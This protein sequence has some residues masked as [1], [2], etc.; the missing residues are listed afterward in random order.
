M[1]SHWFADDQTVT[2][3]LANLPWTEKT[4]RKGLLE[5]AFEISLF[6]L[7]SSHILFL[8]HLRTAAASLFCSFSE[9]KWTLGLGLRDK[10]TI[11]DLA[12]LA[13]NLFE[14]MQILVFQS[15]LYSMSI[16]NFFWFK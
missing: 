5:L 1:H 4:G 9:L 16:A 8:P 15:S 13:R 2:D 14:C 3:Q 12:A 10:E 7:G 11:C 6:S